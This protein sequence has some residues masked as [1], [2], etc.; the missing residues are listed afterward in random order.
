MRP[1]IF[2]QKTW[3]LHKIFWYPKTSE[4]LKGCP[5]NFSTMWDLIFSTKNVRDIPLSIHKTVRNRKKLLKNSRVTFWK[6]SA[7]WDTQILIE[8][9]DM[10]PLI[11]ELFS[12]PEI[13][14]KPEAF[15]YKAFRFG[16]VRKKAVRQN[17]DAPLLLCKKIF[18]KR[19]FLKHQS[20]LQWNISV[21]CDKNFPT[22]N[23]D[24]LPPPPPLLSMKNFSLQKFSKTQNGSL[25]Q[26]SRF[27]ETK[28]NFRQN[29]KASPLL[30]E[31]FRYQ[32][33]FETKK[34]SPTIFIGTVRQRVFNGV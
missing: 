26:F 11:H 15:L 6:F 8:N 17:R 4:S 18:D 16:P 19:I 23:R 14:W 10:P 7:L 12:K 29:R 1:K 25:A 5:R 30:L 31:K 24:T 22:E 3:Y 34:C 33:S 20:V 13:F 32:N 21:Q 2:R 27:R 9:R 28:K